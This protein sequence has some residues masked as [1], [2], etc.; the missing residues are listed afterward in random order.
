[1]IKKTVE[2]LKEFFY[3]NKVL[4]GKMHNDSNKL[5]SF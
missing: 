3:G 4:K 1:M 2:K 5:I